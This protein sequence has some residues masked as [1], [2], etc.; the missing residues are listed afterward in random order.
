[1][2]DLGEAKKILGME[3]PRDR[4]KGTVWLT[5][6]EYLKRAKVRTRKR[7]NTPLSFQA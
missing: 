4:S 1:M 7:V 5:Q 2:K 3:I 6:T